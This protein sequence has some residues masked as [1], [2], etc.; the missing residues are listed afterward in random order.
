[1]P[2]IWKNREDWVRNGS[3]KWKSTARLLEYLLR[4]DSPP[5]PNTDPDTQELVFH[6]K[7]AGNNPKNKIVVYSEFTGLL[8][9]F[10]KVGNSIVG[11]LK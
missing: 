9:N 1:M 3:S 8:P 7:P 4:S 11:C 6:D 2:A 10:I 5:F